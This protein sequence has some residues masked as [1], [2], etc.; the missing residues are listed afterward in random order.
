MKNGKW[1]KAMSARWW[2]F[3]EKFFKAGL[4]GKFNGYSVGGKGIKS[5]A[6][7]FTALRLFRLSAGHFVLSQLN[8]WRL[9]KVF[10]GQLVNSSACVATGQFILSSANNDA[11]R[12]LVIIHQRSEALGDQ[13]HQRQ[14]FMRRGEYK[15]SDVLIS[16]QSSFGLD[17]GQVLLLR[18]VI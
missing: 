14:R 6:V 15:V 13:I 5:T 1:L 9:L 7:N 18:S 3:S 8:L 10:W 16:A 4:V 17:N 2:L 11:R 12:V